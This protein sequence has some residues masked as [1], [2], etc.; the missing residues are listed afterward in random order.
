MDNAGLLAPLLSGLFIFLGAGVMCLGKNNR[1]VTNF[2]LGCGFST[3]LLITLFELLPKAYESCLVRY[4][5]LGVYVNAAIIVGAGFIFARIL[6]AFAGEHDRVRGGANRQINVRSSL[7]S[8][9]G[10]I[11]HNIL[12]GAALYAVFLTS[13]KAGVMMA[14]G[15]G[16]H[17]IPLGMMSASSLISAGAGRIK[18]RAVLASV[19]ISS[20]IGALSAHLFNLD[21][22][23][24]MAMSYIL[25][26]TAGILLDACA[27]DFLPKILER[28][29]EK[30]ALWGI[31]T[32]VAIF[33]ASNLFFFM[34]M[35]SKTPP[36]DLILCAF[37]KV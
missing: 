11:I 29:H 9:I 30:S 20:F 27:F 28:R 19:Y 15:I 36:V 14:V 26:I 12:E 21:A 31:L 33:T 5:G 3:I 37:L 25:G 4:Q 8:S 6:H 10:V 13:P 18:T 23:S 7:T 2:A 34:C 1:K 35:K 17:N 32:G 22:D 24:S 16:F